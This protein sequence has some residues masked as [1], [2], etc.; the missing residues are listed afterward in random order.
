MAQSPE[1]PSRT[2]GD[3]AVLYYRR[4]RPNNL[5]GGC[6]ETNPDGHRACARRHRMCGMSRSMRVLVTIVGQFRIDW[7]VNPLFPV[8]I[9]YCLAAQTDLRGM[10]SRSIETRDDTLVGFPGC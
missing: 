7:G 10:P 2:S 3:V 5:T 8:D 9:R 6:D 4:A 1:A